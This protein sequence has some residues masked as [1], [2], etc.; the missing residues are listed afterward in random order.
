[1]LYRCN[2]YRPS[3]PYHI[4]GDLASCWSAQPPLSQG[5][6][7]LADWGAERYLNYGVPDSS[8]FG[9]TSYTWAQQSGPGQRQHTL[10]PFSPP[11]GLAPPPGLTSPFLTPPAS[12]LSEVEADSE[13]DVVHSSACSTVDTEA[14][15]AFRSADM[16]ILGSEELPTVGSLKHRL[17]TCKPCAFVFKDGPGCTSGVECAFCHLCQP[18]EKKKRKKECKGQ[19]PGLLWH[20]GIPQF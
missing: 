13:P 20:V 15:P 16:G 19:R 18:G 7:F 12:L 14:D 8:F 10:P 4:S 5:Y 2:M 17:G 6:P 9:G 1:V 11:P 3:Q